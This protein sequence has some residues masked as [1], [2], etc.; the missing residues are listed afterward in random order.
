ME[1][2]GRYPLDRI[3]SHAPQPTKR[4]NNLITFIFAVSLLL[5]LPILF[6]RYDDHASNQLIVVALHLVMMTVVMMFNHLGKSTQAKLSLALIYVSFIVCTDA[7]YQ[8]GTDM[9]FFFLLGLF[10]IPILFFQHPAIRVSL[11][12]GLYVALFF[13]SKTVAMSGQ[14]R[15]ANVVSANNKFVYLQINDNHLLLATFSLFLAGVIYV[16]M[17]RNWAYVLQQHH[18][19][20]QLILNILPKVIAK[21]VSSGNSLVADKIPCC[22]MLFA[23][24]SGF[25]KLSKDVSPEQLVKLLNKLFSEFDLICHHQQLEK[26]KTIGDQ[27]MAVCGAPIMNPRHASLACQCAIDML[28]AFIKWRDREKLAVGI[29]IGIHSGDA[30]AGVIGLHKFTYDLWGPDVNY[31]S[32]MESHGLPNKIQVSEDTYQ[33]CRDTFQFTV[34]KNVHLK[35]IGIR[36]TYIVKINEHYSKH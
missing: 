33:L 7:N 4:L 15:A 16:A 30:I 35:D 36:D 11:L 10:V 5:Q 17:R 1:F 26:I 3:G 18:R 32:R 2:K 9:R 31:A 29:R 34:R 28:Q 6:F 23:D 19:Q 27:Y 25:S 24:L 21:R 14:V 22:S 20:Q 8:F 13:I 12:M